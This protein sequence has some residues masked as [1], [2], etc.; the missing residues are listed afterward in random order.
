MTKDLRATARLFDVANTDDEV[1]DSLE[2]LLDTLKRARQAK[3]E[4]AGL[5][6]AELRATLMFR[7]NRQSGWAGGVEAARN[8]HGLLH[9][10]LHVSQE[11]GVLLGGH[12]AGA[13]FA[14]AGVLGA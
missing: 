2:R 3:A 5:P 7:A 1:I 6:P 10:G 8:L 11:D 9:R 12:P 13:Q 14:G 4:L